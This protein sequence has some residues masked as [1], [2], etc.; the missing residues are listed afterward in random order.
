ME[1]FLLVVQGLFGLL[2]ASLIV[3]F[4]GSRNIG[5]LLGGLAFGGSAFASYELAAWWP[6]AVGFAVAWALRL[7]G[8]DPGR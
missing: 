7:L 8:F 2:G 1:T 6:M 3:G 5:L 4:F